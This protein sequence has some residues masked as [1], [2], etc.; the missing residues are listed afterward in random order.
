MR[1][2]AS[3]LRKLLADVVRIA[4]SREEIRKLFRVPLYSSASYLVF[5]NW[6]NSLLGFAFWIIVAR[7]Y[8]AEDVGL[9]SAAM[10]AVGLLASLAHMGLGMGLIRF[11]A[12]SRKRGLM[13]NTVF[14]IGLITSVLASFIFIAG[15]RLWSPALAFI[16]EEPFYMA[17]FVLFTMA[18]VLSIHINQALVAQR[19]ASL[20]LTKNLVFSLLK[21]ILPLAL[22]TVGHSLGIFAS[23]GIATWAAL[24]LALFTFLPRGEPGYH[25]TP[26][27]RREIVRD[28]FS[29]SFA[30]YLSELFWGLSGSIL[31]IMVLS[32]LGAEP[33]AYFYIAWTTAGVL[34]LL[35]GSISTSLFA[36]GCYDEER[37]A[38]NVRRSLKMAFVLLVPAII[39]T[40]VIAD[41]L[42][43]MFGSAYSESGS[44]LLRI[45]AVSTLP[46]TINLIY[47]GIKR[48][49][50]RL[51]L[52]IGIPVFVAAAS[53][54]LSYLLLPR[55]GIAAAGSGW[56]ISQT[57][58]ALAVSAKWL[59]KGRID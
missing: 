5:A 9:A 8:S 6:L 30:N 2:E 4:T 3:P 47:L 24:L 11:L 25:P 52:I 21:L 20:V 44:L 50:K 19:R 56:L 59:K 41:K 33:N 40:L 36:E 58:V 54:G 45:M 55:W 35:P 46:L 29:F 12:G 16:R 51:S 15:L 22:V 42:L 1:L 37:L 39:I 32:Q 49:Q 14:T 34:S 57:A 26:V 31:P 53:V 17:A 10:A 48:V 23:W 43:L 13:L 27:I 38:L 18:A 28:M 7:F